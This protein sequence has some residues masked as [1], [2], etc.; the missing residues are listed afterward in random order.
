[1][2]VASLSSADVT[3]V[4]LAGAK[5][6]LALIDVQA[7]YWRPSLARTHMVSVPAPP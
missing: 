4:P 3:D 5:L 7:P 6:E 2:L 1:M